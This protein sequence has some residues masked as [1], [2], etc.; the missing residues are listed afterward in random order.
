MTGFHPGVLAEPLSTRELDVLRL[1]SDGRSNAEI[2]RELFVERSTVK[3]QTREYPTTGHAAAAPGEWLDAARTAK[4]QAAGLMI[5]VW[6][7]C[8]SWVMSRRAWA[9]S[10][11][12]RCQSAP[13]S[14]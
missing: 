11:R 13:R 14:W 8:S 4:A 7:S 9:W 6:P 2:A 1:L 10:L 3:T 12:R 5:T